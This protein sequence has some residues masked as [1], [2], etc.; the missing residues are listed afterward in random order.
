MSG[1]ELARPVA[2]INRFEVK[3]D[4][5]KFEEIFHEHAQFLRRRAD[6]D[7]L[8]TMRLIERPHIYVHLGHWRTLRAFLD[9]VHD[10]TFL[11]HVERLE[12]LVE[13]EADQAVS[14]ARVLHE[15]AVV[16]TRSVALLRARVRGDWAA[17]ERRFIELAEMCDELGGFGGSDL[18]RSTIRPAL[19]TGV[20]W[21]QDTGALDRALD[22]ERVRALHEELALG[23]DVVVER[24]R[25]LAYERVIR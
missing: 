10:D 9:T 14:V 25:H 1:R 13:T 24:A 11:G 12:P 15:N 8:V 5:G 23:A 20:L 6:F 19:Y 7:F 21:W 22:S 16:G 18:L 4:T 2:V 3:G 17:F